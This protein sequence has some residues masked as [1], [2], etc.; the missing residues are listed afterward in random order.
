MEVRARD[1]TAQLGLEV[2]AL[3][4]DGDR[5]LLGVEEDLAKELGHEGEHAVVAEE[6]VVVGAELAAGLKGLELALELLD[7]DDTLDKLDVVLRDQVL[8]L[9]LRVLG[10]QTDRGG[11]GRGKGRVRE[12]AAW[13]QFHYG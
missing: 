6:E 2:L 8:V 4:V 10:D 12:L 7:T 3:E 5:L 11:G 13:C 9:A 1:S